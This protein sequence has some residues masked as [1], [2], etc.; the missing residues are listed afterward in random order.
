MKSAHIFDPTTETWTKVADMNQARW[1]PTV[2]TLPDGRI[3]AASGTGANEVEVYD[4]AANSWQIVSGATRTFQ[5]LYP[6]LHLLPS[7]Q[8]FYSRCGWQMASTTGTQTAYLTM[9]GSTSGSWTPLGQQ[10][11][12]DRQEG[13]AVLQIDT[14]TTPPTTGIYVVGGGVSG[15]ATD[16]N[17]QTL[18][19]IDLT[20]L[21]PGTDW[22]APALTM[23]FARANVN[24]VLLPDGTIFIVGGQRAG[25]WNFTD[26]DPVLEGEI[27]DP[28]TG[29]F[30]PTAPMLFPRQYHSVA[31][32]L[33]DGRV[34][35][36][37]GVDPTN[38]VERDQRQMEVF[39]PP[40]LDMGP[41]PTVTSSPASASYGATVTLD[42]PDAADV[43]S[44][45]L[46][47][48]N[49]VTHHTDAGH[50]WVRIPIVGTTASSVDVQLPATP[51]IAPPG[52]YMIFI[53]N[54][55]GVPSEA[56]FIQIG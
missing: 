18:E 43:A 6:S 47:R 54:G 55:M 40:Y 22:A 30:T 52:H 38:P 28:V 8:I 23:G 35:C 41:R 9:T 5:E 34:L 7:G 37:G 42:S 46:I 2:L 26:P 17:P 24:A 15:A 50:R 48:P 27:F 12:N 21:G 14:T 11:F 4:A 49:S 13:T 19:S 1:Y 45:V 10:Q 31:V 20:S 53:L 32:L 44:V 56:S 51:T 16:R 25:K 29:T 36:A 3:L 39:S 33:P